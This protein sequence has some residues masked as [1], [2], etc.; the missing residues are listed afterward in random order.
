MSIGARL[1]RRQFNAGAVG[2]LLLPQRALGVTRGSAQ[3]LFQVSVGSQLFT[4]AIDAGRGALRQTAGPFAT[5]A[6]VQACWQHP[7]TGLLYVACSDQNT[8]KAG[9]HA[10]QCF[11]RVA[12]GTLMAIGKPTP[13]AARPIFLTVDHAGAFVITAYN[14]PSMLAV[15]RIG[16]DGGIAGEVVQGAAL[17]TGV[18][19]H[20]VRVLPSNRAVLVMARGNDPTA[21]S[22]E[23]PGSL[24]IFDF[25]GG[26]LTAAQTI[27]PNGGIGFRPRHADFHPSGRWAYVDLESQNVVQTYAI[28]GDRLS[29]RPLFAATTLSTSSAKPGQL[30]SAIVAAPDRRTLYVANRGTGTELYQAER[31]ANGGEN[32]IA[33]FAIDARTGQPRLAQTIDARGI[34]VRTMSLSIDG[35]WLVAASIAPAK[36]RSGDAI[37]IMPGGL[38]LFHVR[39]DGSLEFASKTAIDGEGQ[40]MFWVGAFATSTSGA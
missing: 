10:L 6:E 5:P 15:H 35:R 17:D 12:D 3:Q 36:A 1:D 38:S 28:Q 39:S 34:H 27:Q 9:V 13:L 37:E 26:R 29:A 19:A 8:T 25:A 40:L 18:Y 4:Y 20:Q 22:S 21:S 32:N 31:V 23:D 11:R 14:R 7:G 2:A 24:R 30:A 16:P 33:V